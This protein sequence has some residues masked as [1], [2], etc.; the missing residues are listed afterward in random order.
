[1]TDE[2]VETIAVGNRPVG[3]AA[4]AGRLW[5]IVQEPVT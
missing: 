1:M 5:V 4:G 3:I 2:V